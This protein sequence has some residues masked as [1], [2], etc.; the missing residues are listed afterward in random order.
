MGLYVRGRCRARDWG[1]ATGTGRV[2]QECSGLPRRLHS[3]RGDW[4]ELSGTPEVPAWLRQVEEFSEE[5]PRGSERPEYACG[6]QS[7]VPSRG[8]AQAH[9]YLLFLL[10]INNYL[11]VPAHKLDSPTMS[12]AG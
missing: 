5:L 3:L 11:T 1:S 9:S 4:A 12:R 10:Q 8:A 6:H 7:S 2:V